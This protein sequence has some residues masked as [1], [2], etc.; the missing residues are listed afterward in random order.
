MKQ[1]AMTHRFHTT[2]SQYKLQLQVPSTNSQ[3]HVPAEAMEKKCGWIQNGPLCMY[4][5]W[6]IVKKRTKQT[7]V[8]RQWLQNELHT[9]RPIGVSIESRTT[10][11]NGTNETQLQG[12]TY[13]V[14][15]PYVLLWPDMSWP[16]FL[17]CI[18]CRGFSFVLLLTH[19]LQ[20]SYII[21]SICV[22]AL[23]VLCRFHYR[24]HHDWLIMYNA[25][26]LLVKQLFSYYL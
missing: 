19:Y 17:N 1:T 24:A 11:T 9:S 5:R 8:K 4:V 2:D 6:D 23:T 21:Y 3:S 14:R 12:K 7:V 15:W 13:W 18:K 10:G 26:M 16:G 20:S 22:F 25:F